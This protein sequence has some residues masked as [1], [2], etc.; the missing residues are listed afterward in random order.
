MPLHP[1]AKKIAPKAE[2][3]WDMFVYLSERIKSEYPTADKPTKN[4][5]TEVYLLHARVLYDFLLRPPKDD[6][7]SATHFFDDASEWCTVRSDFCPY[8]RENMTRVNKKL[9]H[10]TYSRL[11]EDEIW[12]HDAIRDE[13]SHAWRTFLEM[14]P[15]DRREWFA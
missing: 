10:L 1:D 13:I 8:L 5:L 6:D 3:E 12:D 14:L 11:T 2:Y 7:V 15:E 9:T 4:F